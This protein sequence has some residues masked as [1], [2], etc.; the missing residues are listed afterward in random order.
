MLR[1]N[2]TIMFNTFVINQKLRKLLFMLEWIL[3]LVGFF[4]SWLI[5]HIYYKKDRRQKAIT[6]S[7]NKTFLNKLSE[8]VKSTIDKTSKSNMSV[9]DLISILKEKVREESN[10]Y[11]G[12][13]GCPVCGSES[14]SNEPDLEVDTDMGDGG[15]LV[16]SPIYIPKV[17]CLDC[18]WRKRIDEKDI[19]D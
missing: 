5:T 19:L 11:L 15:E 16:H 1:C 12:Y 9:V 10:E 14:L 18:G 4:F 6:I 13:K 17:K 7:E 2:N 8:E 3:F